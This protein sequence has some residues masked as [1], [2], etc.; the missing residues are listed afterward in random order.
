MLVKSIH[1][2]FA[3]EDAYRAEALPRELC[4]TSRGEAGVLSFDVARGQ[5]DTHVFATWEEYESLSA[6]DAHTKTAHFQRLVT[7]GLDQLRRR[8][9]V[10]TVVPMQ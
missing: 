4:R 5:D 6:F 2:I 3:P 10:A 8:K 9:H 1:Y 7:N